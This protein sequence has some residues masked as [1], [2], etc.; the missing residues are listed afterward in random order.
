VGGGRISST[1]LNIQVK[2]PRE[3]K[4]EAKEHLNLLK[5]FKLVRTY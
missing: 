2:R 4:K 1:P 5:F 3:K